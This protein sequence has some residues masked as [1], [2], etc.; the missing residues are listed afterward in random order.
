MNKFLQKPFD[1]LVKQAKT[2]DLGKLLNVTGTIGWA[3]SA[4]AFTG[5]IALNDNI[6][7]EQKR[8]LIPQEIADGI[9]NCSL[10]F[11]ATGR[12]NV[13]AKKMIKE[14]RFF[15]KG[16]D[17]IQEGAQ[18]TVTDMRDALVKKKDFMADVK[19][20]KKSVTDEIISKL[21][22][23][24]PNVAEKLKGFSKSFPALISITGSAVAMNLVTPFIRNDVASRIQKRYIDNTQSPELQEPKVTQ[25]INPPVKPMSMNQYLVSSRGGMKI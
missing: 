25:K 16:L 23:E 5:A 8:F 20:G 17:K 19:K 24:S 14:G 18:K 2:E 13:W 22:K 11:I 12:A 6:K 9:I 3:A 7:K 4:A 15:P 10:F 21:E 1:F